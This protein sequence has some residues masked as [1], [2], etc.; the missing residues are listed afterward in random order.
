MASFKLSCP[1]GDY[2]RSTVRGL[3]VAVAIQGAFLPGSVTPVL[4]SCFPLLHPWLSYLE[5][6]KKNWAF[7]SSLELVAEPAVSTIAR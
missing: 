4:S 1:Q 2:G 6:E 3:E 5:N 7:L